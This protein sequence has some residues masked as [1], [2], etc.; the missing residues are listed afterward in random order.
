MLRRGQSFRPIRNGGSMHSKGRRIFE[1]YR[2]EPCY[3][4]SALGPPSKGGPRKPTVPFSPLVRPRGTVLEAS[5]S[6]QSTAA[7]FGD[8]W[9]G[10]GCLVIS[11]T[12][13]N[14]SSKSQCCCTGYARRAP[15]RVEE[16]DYSISSSMARSERA[17]VCRQTT[18]TRERRWLAGS[19]D[20]SAGLG[21]GEKD[22]TCTCVP[23]DHTHQ[24]Y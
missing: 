16:V 10:S 4:V 7:W 14:G 18:T 6:S 23:K 21:Q 20:R 11:A 2:H 5:P 19:T 1:G 12:Q 24:R 15:R 3:L 9:A 13:G 17:C 22:C 8:Q